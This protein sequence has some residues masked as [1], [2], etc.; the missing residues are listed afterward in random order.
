MRQVIDKFKALFTDEHY[1]MLCLQADDDCSKETED[2]IVS[3][4]VKD[5]MDYVHLALTK[6]I[7]FFVEAVLIFFEIDE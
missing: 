7:N 5:K 2:F 1:V 4:P 3:L 6:A